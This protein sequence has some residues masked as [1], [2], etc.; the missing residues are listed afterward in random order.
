MNQ[1]KIVNLRKENLKKLGFESLTEWYYVPGNIYAGCNLHK[2]LHGVP[3]QYLRH[4]PDCGEF[5]NPF[6]VTYFGV[7][8]SLRR[9]K[10]FLLTE[11]RSELKNLANTNIGCYCDDQSCHVEVLLECFNEVVE[12]ESFE[13]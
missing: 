7:T 2:Y 5:W 10:E 13:T 11:K 6:S 9:Y 4:I 12:N 8:E 1:P 3:K